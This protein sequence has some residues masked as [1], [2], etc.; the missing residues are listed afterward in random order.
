MKNQFEM[1]NK[2][3][4]MQQVLNMIPGMGNKISKEASKMTEDKI[5]S[6]IDGTF[7][8]IPYATRERIGRTVDYSAGRNRY[9][10]HLISVATRSFKNKRVG[11]DCSNGSAST[12]A[13]SVFDALGAKTYVINYGGKYSVTIKDENGKVK[14]HVI[15]GKLNAGEE[16]TLHEEAGPAGYTTVTDIKA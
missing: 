1:M 13:K 6:Y 5:E 11:L 9:I 7:G 12:I 16:Y 4:P 2:M 10:G 3:G 8:E 14:P 15:E